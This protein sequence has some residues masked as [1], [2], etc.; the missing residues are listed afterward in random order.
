MQYFSLDVLRQGGKWLGMAR[1]WVQS[2]KLN[3][4][5]VTWGSNDV[6]N[7]PMTIREVEEV[8]A[9][10]VAS[11][12]NNIEDVEKIAPTGIQ[13][14]IILYAKGWYGKSDKG[15]ISDLSEIMVKVCALP[16]ECISKYDVIDVI[17]D[18]FS[19][20]VSESLRQEALREILSNRFQCIMNRTPEEIMLGKISLV[21][22]NYVD[23]SAK[24][25]DI[26]FS[27]KESKFYLTNNIVSGTVR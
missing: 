10:A 3:G 24:L 4:D 22:G 16:L 8:C 5:K 20:Y 7:P 15:I 12:M 26:F 6:L 25:P 23:M 14:H 11:V 18:T 1:S 17:I 27:N 19:I 9:Y 13:K 2:H 21:R